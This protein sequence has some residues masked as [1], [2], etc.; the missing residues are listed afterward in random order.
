MKRALN[1][2]HGDCGGKAKK[3][4]KRAMNKS[5]KWPDFMRVQL[6]LENL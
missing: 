6:R 4:K 3:K 5:N 1:S 2:F